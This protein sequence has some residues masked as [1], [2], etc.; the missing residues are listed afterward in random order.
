MWREKGQK[1]T[2]TLYTIRCYPGLYKIQSTLKKKKILLLRDG[3]HFLNAERNKYSLNHL[4]GS[5]ILSW[6]SLI[7]LYVSQA[8]LLGK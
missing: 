6:K 7:E 4:K 5:L 8:N 1:F 2:V 3:K